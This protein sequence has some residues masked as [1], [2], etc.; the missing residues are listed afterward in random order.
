MAR[1]SYQHISPI[2]LGKPKTLALSTSE[3]AA[4]LEVRHMIDNA[5][6]AQST[7]FCNVNLSAAYRS[8]RSILS[9]RIK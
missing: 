9:N 3:R 1:A 6:K 7:G 4:L 8:I 2:H 5:L